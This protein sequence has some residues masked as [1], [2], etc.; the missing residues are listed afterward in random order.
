MW[1]FIK[2]G[3]EGNALPVAAKVAKETSLQALRKVLTDRKTEVIR[4]YEQFQAS[5]F[6]GEFLKSR[7]GR[8]A[9]STENPQHVAVMEM[10]LKKELV[11][12]VL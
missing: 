8:T 2:W 9:H 3:E 1:I 11:I 6:L 4:K 10:F 12:D 7:G 5:D